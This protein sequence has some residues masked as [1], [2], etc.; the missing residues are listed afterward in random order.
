MFVKKMGGILLVVVT[1][2]NVLFAVNAGCVDRPEATNTTETA[3]DKVSNFFMEVGC[4]LKSGAEKVKERVESSYN[5]LKSKITPDEFKNSTHNDVKPPTDDRITFKD[6]PE[7]TM[8]GHE[9]SPPEMATEL[10]VPISTSTSTATAPSV[11]GANNT[12]VS[13]DDRAT[14]VAPEMCKENEVKIK[15]VCQERVDI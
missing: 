4:T 14:L 8:L 12:I 2:S 11:N 15:G 1:L 13:I 5:Y 10:P 6:N 3:A 7:D 9:Q